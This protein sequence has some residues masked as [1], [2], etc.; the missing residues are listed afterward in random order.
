MTVKIF[1]AIMKR[2]S[3]VPVSVTVTCEEGQGLSISGLITET[4]H[5]D[6]SRVQFALLNCG[7]GF[8]RKK[9]H[10]DIEPAIFDSGDNLMLPIA[11]GVLIATG[12]ITPVRN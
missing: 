11:T 4:V 1:S 6:L 8:K 9:M 10:I 12:M 5:R 3:A 7:F 2:Y